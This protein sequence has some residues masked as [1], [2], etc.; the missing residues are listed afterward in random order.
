MAN[1]YITDEAKENLE[2]LAKLEHRNL[3]K[4]IEFMIADRL[5]LM[6]QAD[7]SSID[8]ATEIYEA[9]KAFNKKD[10]ITPFR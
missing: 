8:E 9:S 3:S 4:Q 1:I 10:L 5:L 6:S 2:T 7:S